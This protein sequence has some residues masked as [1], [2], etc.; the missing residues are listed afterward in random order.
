MLR[1][2]PYDRKFSLNDDM[3]DENKKESFQQNF[4][5]VFIETKG[6]M[7]RIVLTLSIMRFG[8]ED[9]L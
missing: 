2:K 6:S 4:S 9:R 8:R 1:A 7:A 5:S 3:N